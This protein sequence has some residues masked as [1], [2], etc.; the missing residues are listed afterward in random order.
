MIFHNYGKSE[1]GDCSTVW[2]E[3]LGNTDS[4]MVRYSVPYRVRYMYRYMQ[5]G[6][7]ACQRGFSAPRNPECAHCIRIKNVMINVQRNQS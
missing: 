1:Y 5:S 2:D 4:K 6:Y 7:T 3:A